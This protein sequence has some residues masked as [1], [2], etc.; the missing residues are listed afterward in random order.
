M[1]NEIVIFKDG[2][3]ELEVTVSENKDTVWLSQE[4][5]AELFD[6]DRTRVTRHINNIYKDGEL[7]VEST[8]AENALVQ[9]E[10]SRKVKRNVK[11]YNLD[12][13]ISVGYRVKSTRRIT[14]RKWATN[15]LK[16]YMIKGYAI[17]Q[18]RIEA[19]N[20]TVEIQSRIIANT[21]EIDEKDVYNVVAAYSNTLSLLDD[22]D[23]G[24]IKKPEGN[25]SIYELTYK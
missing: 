22:Y 2:E 24:C 8:C 19:L 21:L 7:S 10:G 4:Q 16:D 25:L 14:F 6:V 1:T 17:N 18:K 15:I 12:M 5:M 9:F 11:Y 20:K 13:I 23:H 3:L